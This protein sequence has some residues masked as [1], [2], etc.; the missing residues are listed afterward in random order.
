MTSRTE[1][2][3]EHRLDRRQLGALSREIYRRVRFEST[4]LLGQIQERLARLKPSTPQTGFRVQFT[5]RRVAVH[6]YPW[7]QKSGL[8]RA[9]YKFCYV[10]YGEYLAVPDLAWEPGENLCSKDMGC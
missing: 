9:R 2:H 6:E 10:G 1:V 5:L 3:L 7:S 4:S 8:G